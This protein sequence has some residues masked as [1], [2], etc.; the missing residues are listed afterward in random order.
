MKRSL[1]LDAFRGLAIAAM[2]LVNNPGSWSAVYAPLTHAQWH[3]LTPTD[4]VFPFFLFAVGN[5]M[6]FS[7]VNISSSKAYFKKVFW[8]VFSLFTAGLLLALFPL[9]WQDWDYTNL[10]IMGVLQR[11]ALCYGI[12]AIVIH[13]FNIRQI[14]SLCIA[15]LGGYWAML[16]L[17]GDLTLADNFVRKVDV[18]ILGENH[19]Y[20]LEGLPFDPE[21]LLST[22]PAV[23]TVLLGYLAGLVLKYKY[24]WDRFLYLFFAGLALLVVGLTWDFIF[25]M[26]KKLWT[27]SFVLTTGG[28]AAIVLSFWVWLTQ[29]KGREMLGV[30]FQILGRNAIFIFFASGLWAKTIGKIMLNLEGKQTSVHNYAYQTFFKPTFGDLNGSL[31][32]AI[33]TLFLFWLIA[34]WMYRKRIF[35]KI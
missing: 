31:G 33:C 26:N 12:S 30:P 19:L 15:I 14:M 22:F 8:R 10:R 3:G 5:A 23:V 7:G 11:I 34:W 35:V 27:S 9:V 20:Q 17:G 4:L 25:P 29:I 18:F 24:T 28:L 16:L 21:G 2:L 13:Y 6:V 1:P 32:F